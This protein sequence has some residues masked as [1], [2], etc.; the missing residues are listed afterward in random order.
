MTEMQ[1][2]EDKQKEVSLYEKLASRTK[3]LIGETKVKSSETMHSA[4][5]K[6]KQE[7]VAAGDFKQEK[8]EKLKAFLVRD[9]WAA[10]KNLAKASQTTKEVLDPQ[11]LSTGIQSSLAHILT[12]LGSSLENLGSKLESHLEYKTGEITSLGHLKCKKCGNEIKMH[13]AG[14]VPPCPECRGTEFRKSY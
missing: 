7:M 8:G 4:M 12:A 3:E 10:E 6:A 11:R 5:E 14:H 1:R 9:L 13:G 2:D